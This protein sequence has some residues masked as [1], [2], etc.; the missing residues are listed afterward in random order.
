MSNQAKRF[1]RNSNR[2]SRK[3]EGTST[4]QPKPKWEQEREVR[5]SQHIQTL[6]SK[7]DE[8]LQS[9]EYN[10]VTVASGS[11]GTGKSYIACRY[12][13]KQLLAGEIKKIVITRPYVAL[14]NRTT[15]FKPSTDLEKLRGFVLPMLHYLGEVLGKG[16]VEEHLHSIDGKIELAPLESLRGRSFDNTIIVVDESQNCVPDEI[17]ALVTRIGINSKMIFCGDPVQKDMPESKCGLIYLER[18]IKRHNIDECGIITF[19]PEDCVR[20]GICKAFTI[21][22]N[23]DLENMK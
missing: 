16:M 13:A 4:H 22:I 19:R 14:A 6:T 8:M 7:Q 9:C 1:E 10:T 2:K 17:N 18:L 3:A 20:S 12:A 21:A 11:S 5:G 23:R 15:G